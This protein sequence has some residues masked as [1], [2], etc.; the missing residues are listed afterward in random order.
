[1]RLDPRS[2]TNVVPPQLGHPPSADGPDAR[3]RRL[4]PRHTSRI[5]P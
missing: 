5:L 4:H 1:M 2:V 3:R